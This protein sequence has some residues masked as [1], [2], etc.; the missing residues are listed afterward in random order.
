MVPNRQREDKVAAEG[1]RLPLFERQSLSARVAVRLEVSN[2]A[3]S[4]AFYEELIGLKVT[5]TTSDTVAFEASLVLHAVADRSKRSHFGRATEDLFRVILAVPSISDLMDR[6]EGM[7]HE[8]FVDA[9]PQRSGR[10]LKMTD[11]DGNLVQI[12][13]Q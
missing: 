13:E 8:L 3:R 1:V 9:E 10:S 11:P 6:V 5:K 7:K 2:L 4:R 12:Y